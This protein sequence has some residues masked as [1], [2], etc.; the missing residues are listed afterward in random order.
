M[1]SNKESDRVILVTGAGGGLGR[2]LVEG[3]ASLGYKNIACQVRTKVSDLIHVLAQ[4]EFPLEKHVFFAD[5]TNEEDVRRMGEQITAKFGNPWAVINVAGS[6]S[7]SMSWKLSLEDYK[8]VIDNNLTS[9]FLTCRQ[10]I[11]AMREQGTGRIINISSVVAHSGVPGASHYCA[12]KAGIEGFT[13]AIALELAPKNVTANALALGYFDTGIIDQ[14]PQN[15]QD[16]IKN[17]TP[18]KRFGKPDEFVGIVRYLLSDASAFM[19]GEVL[20]INGGYHL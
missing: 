15:M 16:V 9:T 12:A 5:L 20:N 2:G 17:M 18:A 11:P 7:N 8:K 6:S 10:F 1:L 3:L 4:H 13:R 14:V 19:T